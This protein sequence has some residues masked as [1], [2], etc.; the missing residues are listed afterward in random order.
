MGIFTEKETAFFS[1]QDTACGA[2]KLLQILSG[3]V[4][5]GPVRRGENKEK[6]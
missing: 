6:D 1:A 2:D 4:C 3:L 5:L